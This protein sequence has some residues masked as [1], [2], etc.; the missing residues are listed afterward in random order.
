MDSG[1][2]DYHCTM[3]IDTPKRFFTSR[4]FRTLELG[5]RGCVL[6]LCSK[7]SFVIISWLRLAEQVCNN[8]KAT[9]HN[10]VEL[11]VNLIIITKKEYIFK[12]EEDSC[13][14]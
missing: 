8:A 13:Y 9:F 2:I 7:S 1:C 6:L 4:S 5:F 14:F 12:K 11:S 10:L 3:R